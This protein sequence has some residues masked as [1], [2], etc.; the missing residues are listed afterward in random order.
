MRRKPRDLLWIVPLALF[1]TSPLWQP[2]VADF[3]RPRGDFDQNKA[4]SAIQNEQN[5]LMDAVTLTLSSNGKEEWL[6]K[7]ERAQT[8]KND[9]VIEM[10]EVDATYIGK[11]RPPTHIVSRRGKYLLNDRH[12]VLIDDVVISRPQSQEVLYTDLLHYYDDTKMAVSPGAVELQGP[13]FTLKGGRMD[14]D[15]S[16]DGYDFGDHVE[17]NL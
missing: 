2:A 1:V 12:L 5:F 17:V 11:D 6:I 14:Y 10:V 13:D 3:L 9:R 4:V 7:A 15:L 8:G 16:T